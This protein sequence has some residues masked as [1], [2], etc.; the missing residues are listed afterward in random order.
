MYKVLINLFIKKLNARI[1]V[2][3]GLSVLHIS[4]GT[5]WMDLNLNPIVL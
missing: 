5:N 2:Y 4:F 1:I 3:K